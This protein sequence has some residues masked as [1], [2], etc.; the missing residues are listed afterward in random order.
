MMIDPVFDNPPVTEAPL[1]SY[2]MV[3]IDFSKDGPVFVPYPPYK[4][5]KNRRKMKKNLVD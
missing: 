5:K 3:F 4:K 2:S 1:S